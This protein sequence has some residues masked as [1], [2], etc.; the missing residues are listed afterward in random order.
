MRETLKIILKRLHLFC[1]FHQLN[2]FLLTLNFDSVRVFL[3]I[4]FYSL[5]LSIVNLRK[6]GSESLRIDFLYFHK[7]WKL[8]QIIFD[9]WN[10]KWT[11]FVIWTYTIK[12]A[13]LL[14]DLFLFNLIHFV[15]ASFLWFAHHLLITFQWWKYICIWLLIDLPLLGSFVLI[16]RDRHDSSPKPEVLLQ[17]VVYIVVAWAYWIL[18]KQIL[19][20]LC[21]LHSYNF[22][23]DF[24]QIQIHFIFSDN[25]FR[26]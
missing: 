4:P 14:L 26:S 16:L 23:F 20:K 18:R 7:I 15:I 8:F 22:L 11:G 10:I 21:V 25:I 1:E 9:C 5:W 17:L 3:W 13:H 2:L 24:F 12:T 6:I 19:I